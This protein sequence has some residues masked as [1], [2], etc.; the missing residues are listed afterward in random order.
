M[1]MQTSIVYGY[2]F[3]LA[4][5]TDERLR[6]FILAHAATIRENHDDYADNLLDFAANNFSEPVEDAFCDLECEES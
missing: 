4:C 5:I 2:G 3:Q 1:S 6:S